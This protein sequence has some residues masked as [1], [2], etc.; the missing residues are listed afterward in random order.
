MIANL[1]EMTYQFVTP[2]EFEH[3]AARRWQRSLE[4]RLPAQGTEIEIEMSMTRTMDSCGLAALLELHEQM[5]HQGGGVT[6]VN[7]SPAVVQVLELTGMHRVLKV[8]YAGGPGDAED[9]R[10]VLV[11]E[12][13]RI[14]R[15]VAG[16]SLK[17][18]GRRVLFAENGCE[19]LTLARQERPAVIVLDYVLPMMDGQAALRRLKQ[20][21]RTADIPVVIMSANAQVASGVRDEFDGAACFVSKPFSPAALRA[22]VHRLMMESTL[23]PTA[24]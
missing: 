2:S 21:A 12:D 9:Q 18:L 13:D 6:L 19:A 23:T 17:S 10:P 16:M 22:E 15:S 7:P 11:V 24:P 14:I 4:G 1:K 5:Q 20:D 3:T 8:A